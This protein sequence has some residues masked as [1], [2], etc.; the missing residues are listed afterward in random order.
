MEVHMEY[1]YYPGEW[2]ERVAVTPAA[3][4][5]GDVRVLFDDLSEHDDWPIVVEIPDNDTHVRAY[6]VAID[7]EHEKLVLRVRLADRGNSDGRR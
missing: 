6:P 1:D 5:V 2:H 3:L 4:T 7:I